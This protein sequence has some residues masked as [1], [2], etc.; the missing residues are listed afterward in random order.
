M[1][2]RNC[3]S[4]ICLSHAGG[5]GS[6]IIPILSPDNGDAVLSACGVV[7][8]NDI[9]RNSPFTGNLNIGATL[10]N[11]VLGLTTQFRADLRHQSSFYADHMNLQ[12]MPSLTTLNLSATMRNQNWHF[13]LFVNNVTDEDDPLN[14]STSNYY[15][16]NPDPSVGAISAGSWVMRVSAAYFANRPEEV[17]ETARRMTFILEGEL[18]SIEERSNTVATH[19]LRL[20]QQQIGAILGAVNDIAQRHELSPKSVD[21]V[22]TKLRKLQKRA[23]DQKNARS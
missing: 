6:N 9:P 19:V 10:P 1:S 13:R 20:R 17:L 5:G 3:N 16:A 12:E 14:V 23:A 15:Y 11:E 22:T 7:N 2:A 21:E 8:G 4:L 18:D